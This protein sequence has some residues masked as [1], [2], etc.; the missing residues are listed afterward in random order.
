MVLWIAFT[1]QSVLDHFGV[2]YRFT[3]AW[4]HHHHQ[5]TSG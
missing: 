4:L 5:Q 2:D 1:L 3:F